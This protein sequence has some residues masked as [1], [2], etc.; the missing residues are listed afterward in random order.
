MNNVTNF[1]KKY[2]MIIFIETFQLLLKLSFYLNESMTKDILSFLIEFSNNILVLLDL[3]C[4][5][6]EHLNLEKCWILVEKI[7]ELK[8]K[9]FKY[10]LKK[11]IE[12]LKK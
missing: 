10:L 1:D 2:Q 3:N 4:F 6:N 9:N 5:K 12:K 7:D 11:N 8:F